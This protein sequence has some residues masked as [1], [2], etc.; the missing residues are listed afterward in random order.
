MTIGTL[1]EPAVDT[2]DLAYGSVTFEEKDGALQVTYSTETEKDLTYGLSDASKV[3][4]VIQSRPDTPTGGTQLRIINTT[5]PLRIRLTNVRM[6][7]QTEARS[8]IDVMGS[9]VLE[10]AG[11]NILVS[12]SGVA[13]LY[14]QSGKNLTLTGSGSLDARVNLP[15]GA[16]E[17]DMAE[18]AIGGS[19]KSDSGMI[20]I[21]SG[22][23]TATGSRGG[24]GIGGGYKGSGYVTINGGIVAA[25]GGAC[26]A[27]IGGGYESGNVTINGGIVTAWGGGG[28]FP[29][30]AGIGGGGGLAIW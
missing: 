20:V 30:G 4:E 22:R 24:A 25:R 5:S 2:F 3:Y 11:E 1:I 23:I 7:N 21:E 13:A 8:P 28:D 27:G 14:V 15:D 10:L 17:D 29:A 12:N 9:A 26:S 19:E 16:K 6:D 18:A